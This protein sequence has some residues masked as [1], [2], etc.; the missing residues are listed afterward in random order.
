MA[1]LGAEF[2]LGRDEMVAALPGVR[3]YQENGPVELWRDGKTGR[4]CIVAWMCAGNVGCFID[5]ADLM[6]VLEC[7]HA[8]RIDDREGSRTD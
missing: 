4:L 3:E 8:A 5:L 7:G 1:E 2:F 6:S